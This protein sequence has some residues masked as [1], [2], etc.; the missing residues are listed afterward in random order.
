MITTTRTNFKTYP[1]FTARYEYLGFDKRRHVEE[2]IVRGKNEEDAIKTLGKIIGRTRT[3]DARWDCWDGI[4]NA[5]DLFCVM[6]VRPYN[7]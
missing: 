2:S 4:L 6:S 3:Q 1:R 5:F 7:A